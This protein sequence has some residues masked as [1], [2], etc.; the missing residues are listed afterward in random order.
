MVLLAWFTIM[1]ANTVRVTDVRS[2]QD[3][4]RE[5]KP[6]TH[7]V[8]ARGQYPQRIYAENLAGSADRPIVIAGENRHDP[9]TFV[10]WQLSR[11][12][13]VV[14]RDL[15]FKGAPDNGLNIDD[16]GRFGSSHHVTLERISVSDLPQGNHDG[17]KLSG[18]TDFRVSD[19]K[20]ERWGGSAVDMVGCHNGSISGC[21]FRSGGGNAVQA[22]GGS[23]SIRIVRCR[24]EN[25]GQR[26]VNL[27]GSTGRPY[28]RPSSAT[29]EARDLTVEGCTF[30]GGV[31]PIAFVGVDGAKVR[32]NTIYR[33][34][35]WAV[36]ILQ[37]TTAPEFVRCRS[38]RF[39][40]NLVVFSES[41]WASGGVNVG[42]NTSPETFRFAENFWY[43][44]ERPEH[45]R[46][47][48]PTP[49]TRGVYGRDPMLRDPERGDLGVREDS[50]ARAYGA[51]AY[52]H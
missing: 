51:H 36:R 44:L 30:I 2:L 16:G 43:C 4:L 18:I 22:K 29:W 12:S 40:R 49:E 31:S 6:G 32:Y 17:I 37:E 3:A 23:S 10:A 46:P 15:A 14:L 24:F 41:A 9:P 52:T 50:P 35:R 25:P 42:P 45:S 27:G 13:H 7:I 47:N 21:T 48:L 8:I 26:G 39:E 20:V 1:Q 38:G 33:P 19:C 11:V 34:E 28:F 5:A